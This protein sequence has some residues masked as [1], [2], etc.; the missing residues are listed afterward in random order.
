MPAPPPP[1]KGQ[2]VL[3]G[4]RPLRPYL[5]RLVCGC[6]ATAPACVVVASRLG[7]GIPT[8]MENGP[9]LPVPVLLTMTCTEDPGSY[10]GNPAHLHEV[11]R[12]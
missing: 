10:P 3:A 4:S 7:M 9:G 6:L 2:D 11:G 12:C 8:G 5:A 1:L